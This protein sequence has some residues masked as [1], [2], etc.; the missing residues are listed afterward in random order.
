MTVSAP[1]LAARASH[2][3]VGD[4][5]GTN[6]R[7]ALAELSDPAHPGLRDELHLPSAQYASL[8]DALAAY[9]KEVEAA[10]EAPM[11]VLAVAGPVSDGEVQLTNLSWHASERALR[12]LGLGRVRLINDFRAL[13]ASADALEA[14]DLDAIGPAL[15]RIA[16]ATIAIM[17]AGTG[18]GAAALVREPG[19]AIALAGEGGHIGFSP[20]D[21]VEAQILTSLQRRFG[22]VSIERIVSGPGLVNLY[23][24]LCEI[25]GASPV[26]DDPHQIVDAAKNDEPYARTAV[27][28][29]C[30]IFGAAAG[31]IAL[32]FGARGGVL[33]AGGLSEAMEDFM[34]AGSF[35]ARFEGKGR[36]AHFARKI[37][38]HLIRRDDAALLGCARLAATD[39]RISFRRAAS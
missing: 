3:V 30:A 8:K 18:F 11:A 1:E 13:A 32:T 29:F 15:P 31:D 4:I 34:K 22:R 24:A 9:L 19:H 28:R 37:P 27:E 10:K 23:G 25:G 6:A 5:G 16:D 7:F 36:L 33:L 2:A 39:Q 14:E 12:G 20:E 35:R 38:T 21:E 17:G 26:F